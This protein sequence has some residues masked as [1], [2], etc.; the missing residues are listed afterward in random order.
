MADRGNPPNEGKGNEMTAE[1]NPPPNSGLLCG[2]TARHPLPP[3]EIPESRCGV[4]GKR[5][6]GPSCRSFS[7]RASIALFWGLVLFL[8]GTSH[9]ARHL[10]MCLGKPILNQPGVNSV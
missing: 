8:T 7:E 4:V 6:R 10:V 9:G 5:R 3:P 2:F 1:S